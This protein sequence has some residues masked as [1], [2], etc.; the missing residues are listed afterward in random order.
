MEITHTESHSIYTIKLIGDI[1]PVEIKEIK[2]YCEPYF[3]KA[4]SNRTVSGAIIDLTFVQMV[5][6]IGIGYFC[7]QH[8][9]FKKLKKRLI[10]ANPNAKLYACLK[11][12][13][14][15]E[16]LEIYPD[17]ISALHDLIKPF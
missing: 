6:S 2:T 9:A 4:K 5:Q 13:N 3:E 1:G 12:M 11:S 14:L 15:H 8:I 16:L 17:K 10:L 7:G